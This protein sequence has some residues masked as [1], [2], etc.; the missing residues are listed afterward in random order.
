MFVFWSQG[1]EK[2]VWISERP[3][4]SVEDR[5]RDFKASVEATPERKEEDAA[6]ET[7]YP[8]DRASLPK[9][10]QMKESV[11][12]GK[13]LTESWGRGGCGYR[14]AV[15]MLLLWNGSVTAETHWAC[16]FYPPVLYFVK[17]E[18]NNIPVY[19]SDSEVLGAPV[20]NH[21]FPSKDSHI[22]IYIW[23]VRL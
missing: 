16:V 8:K 12:E 14:T 2:L 3:T 7:S 11:T 23:M 4:P 21:C 10:T 20:A 9:R 19:V 5:L 17:W 13:E 18:E 15:A 1:A 6:T 22:T